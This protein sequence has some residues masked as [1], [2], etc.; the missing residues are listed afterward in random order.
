MSHGFKVRYN[1]YKWSKTATGVSYL[2]A[3][4]FGFGIVFTLATVLGFVGIIKGTVNPIIFLLDVVGLG[5]GYLL[6]DVLADKIAKKAFE[7]AVEQNGGQIPAEYLD[8][9][10]G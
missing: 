1:T 6:R 10:A 3:T 9:E 8:E 2:G 7:K 4:V 5:G